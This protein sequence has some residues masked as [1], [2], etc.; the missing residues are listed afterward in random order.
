MIDLV[1]FD[2]DGVVVDSEIVSNRVLAEVATELGQPMTASEAVSFFGGTTLSQQVA[3]LEGLVGRPLGDAFAVAL[4]RRTLDAL[5]TVRPIHGIER[6]L[7]WLDTTPV[8]IGSTSASDRIEHCLKAVGLTERFRG[9]VF[10]VSMVQ[11]NKPSPDIFL[12]AARCMGARPERTLIIEDSVHGVQAGIA[13]GMRV[14][15]LTAASHISATHGDRLRQAGAHEVA[16]DYDGVRA[17]LGP[18]LL[19]GPF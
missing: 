17:Y 15:G 2:F 9:H 6:F 16:G 12:H 5:A 8:C 13:A 3:K 14:I 7:A 11:R 10:S 19:S 4:H 1:I 18:H